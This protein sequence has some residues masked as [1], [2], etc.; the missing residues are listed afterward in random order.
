[1]NSAITAS[2]LILAWLSFGIFFWVTLKQIEAK[3]TAAGVAKN[4]IDVNPK[5]QGFADVDISKLLENAAKF[6]D[7]LTKAGPGLA[8]LGASVLFL[9]IAGVS[10]GIINKTTAVNEKPVEAAKAPIKKD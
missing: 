9:A 7:S 2:C 6:V 8:A 1:M 5:A 4:A 3:D 10:T